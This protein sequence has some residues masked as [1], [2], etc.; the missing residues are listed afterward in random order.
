[1]LKIVLSTNYY[2]NHFTGVD[3]IAGRLAEFL[4][5]HHD[6][7]IDWVSSDCFPPSKNRVSV[8]CFPV[9]S[10]NF[11]ERKFFIH[12][13]L[14]KSFPWRELLEI[15]RSADVVHLHDYAY[16]GNIVIFLIAKMNKK[17]VV[18]SQHS[19]FVAY[20]SIFVCALLYSLN[21]T[22]GKFML[23]AADQVIFISQAVQE[24]FSKFVRF[25]SLPVII[26]NGVDGKVFFPADEA[27]KQ[28]TR[29]KLSLNPEQ[30]MFFFAGR[31][32][33]KKGLLILRDLAARFKSVQ[34]VFAGWGPLDPLQWK[35]P[36]VKVFKYLSAAEMAE[37]YQAADLF[38]LPSRGE[39]LPLVIQE[40]MSCGTPVMTS[41]ENASLAQGL[42]EV[43]L[44][45]TVEGEDAA[46]QWA[47]QIEKILSTPQTV[48]NFKKKAYDFSVSHWTWKQCTESY[49][50]IF[51]ESISKEKV[52]NGR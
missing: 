10:T 21:H 12:Y 15:I 30:K 6:V 14:W 36:N 1:M 3:I 43:V 37:F 34:W 28:R 46:E 38:I 49:A 51:T 17:P 20:P 31:F 4:V 32:I 52:R 44:K 8:S 27:A 11:I 41:T 16:F 23:S 39:G 9:K 29:E 26:P 7:K 18:I 24:H 45:E 42:Q 50:K 48:L 22:V 5:L 13:P 25:R 33:E 40:A 47:L 19:R 2:S 35:L